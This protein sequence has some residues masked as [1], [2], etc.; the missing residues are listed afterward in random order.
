MFRVE[1]VEAL[2]G[3]GFK[4]GRVEGLEGQRFRGK[5]EGLESRV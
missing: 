3:L 4:V 2:E 5:F 1:R